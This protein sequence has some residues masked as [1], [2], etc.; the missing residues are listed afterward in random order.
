MWRI[1]HDHRQY[2]SS[3]M[4]GDS[5]YGH[6]AL[7]TQKHS[8]HISVPLALYRS[9]YILLALP[10]FLLINLNAECSHHFKFCYPRNFKTST[11]GQKN[12]VTCKISHTMKTKSILTSYSYIGLLYP[13]FSSMK[14]YHKTYKPHDFPYNNFL[15][16]YCPPGHIFT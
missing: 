1:S 3:I 2:T 4:H 15:L 11:W 9:P 6:P 12:S 5:I 10:Y 13:E 8:R 7:Y 14:W 16:K